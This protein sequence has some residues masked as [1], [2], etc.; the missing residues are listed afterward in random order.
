M[1]TFDSERRL[2]TV[3][4]VAAFLGVPVKTIY[5]WR[6]RDYGPKGLRVGKYVRFRPEDV[7]AWVAEQ[8]DQRTR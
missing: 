1:T 7:D 4:D 3:E 8:H 6:T 2:W 5:D